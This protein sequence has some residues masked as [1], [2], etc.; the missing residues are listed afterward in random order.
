MTSFSCGYFLVFRLVHDVRQRPG[1]CRSSCV[2]SSAGARVVVPSPSSGWEVRM[3]RNVTISK[4]Y[5]RLQIMA[6]LNL[7]KVHYS[8]KS[9]LLCHSVSNHFAIFGNCKRPNCNKA[10]CL[11]SI[12]GKVVSC[13]RHALIRC[14]T[15]AYL[16]DKI[17]PNNIRHF[18]VIDFILCVVNQ[19]SRSRRSKQ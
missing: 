2:F 9:Y 19:R 8:L 1:F 13:K 15:S 18:L 7:L 6:A 3:T 17:E 14:I 4:N 11:R 10:L 12:T 5:R 16:E